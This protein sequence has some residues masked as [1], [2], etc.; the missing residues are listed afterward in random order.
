[1]LNLR[2]AKASN[3]ARKRIFRAIFLKF[4]DTKEFAT[5]TSKSTNELNNL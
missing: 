1:M 2:P 5:Y 3:P 4:Y